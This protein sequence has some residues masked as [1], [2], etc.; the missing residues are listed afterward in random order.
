MGQ[1]LCSRLVGREEEMAILAKHLAAASAGQGSA[2]LLLGEAGVGKSRLTHEVETLAVRRG[3]RVLRGRSVESS[4]APYRPIAEALLSCIRTT[5]PPDVPALRPFQSILGRLIPEWREESQPTA[6]EIHRFM[7]DPSLLMGEAILRLLRVLGTPSGCLVVLEDLHWA[8]GDS[9]AVIEYLIDNIATEPVLLLATLRSN[10][11]SAALAQARRTAARRVGRVIELS[12]LDRDC[13]EQM[14]RICLGGV[15]EPVGQEPAQG[16]PASVIDLLASYTEGLPFLIEELLTAWIE[17]GALSRRDDRW[18]VAAELPP[19]A[20]LTFVEAVSR[21]LAGLDGE[22][23]RL[24]EIAAILG[25]HFDWTLLSAATG[26]SDREVLERLATAI[27]AQLVEAVRVVVDGPNGVVFRFRHALTR[28]A[29]LDRIILPQRAQLS[30]QM[31]AIIERVHPDLPGTWC[32]LAAGLAEAAGATERAAELLLESGRRSVTSGALA[33][34]ESVLDQALRLAVGSRVLWTEIIDVLLE[35]LALAGKWE[36]VLTVGERLLQVLRQELASGERVASVYLRMARASLGAGHWEETDAYLDAARQCGERGQHAGL[37]AQVNVLR[38]HLSIERGRLDEAATLASSA[39]TAAQQSGQPEIACEALE[40]LGRCARVRDLDQAAVAFERARAIAEEHGLRVWQIRAMHELGTL[41]IFNGCSLERLREARALAIEAG[42]MATAAMVDVQLAAAHDARG[43]LEDVL[44][45]ARRSRDIA[46]RFRLAMTEATAWLFEARVYSHMC[47]RAEMEAAVG[48][49]LRL[50]GG[51]PD[52]VAGAWEARAF[53][54]LQE[55]KR[56]QALSDV[57]MAMAEIRGLPATTPAPYRGLWALLRTVEGLDGPEACAEVRRSGA[58]ILAINRGY[59]AFA[60]AVILARS[61][62]GEEATVA[63]A[64]ANAEMAGS[65]HFRYVALRL[66]A[67]VAVQEGWGDPVPWL[68]EAHS[69]FEREGYQPMAAA[70]VGLLRC[71]GATVAQRGRS[72][73]GVPPYF[74]SL[75]V[76][77]REMDVLSELTDGLSNREIGQKLYLSPR[78]VE[79]HVASLLAKTGTRTRAQLAARAVADSAPS[80][81]S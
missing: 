42:A 52:I 9:L 24:I 12:S 81:S 61:G 29:I 78:T 77:R 45:A 43:E 3:T 80:R 37:R 27:D 17:T 32:D 31:L 79:K 18:E 7:D 41:D 2:V 21:R 8:D 34:A 55:E 19:L 22:T 49:A 39:L 65:G 51:E 58:T 40:V 68:W 60:D 72:Y 71:A 1:V 74:R 54:S 28:A 67:E 76:T 47:R 36:R 13:I 14:A 11:Q 70:C 50:A 25:R 63:V 23:C 38:A 75:G 10:E 35:A 5:G 59:I 33:T 48:E 6:T 16:Y 30:A 64:R 69:Y 73:S 62:G 44:V 53:A 26:F 15:D 46:S 57:E 4:G 66:V 20:P 56:A